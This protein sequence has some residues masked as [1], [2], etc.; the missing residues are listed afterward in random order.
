MHHHTLAPLETAHDVV[1]TERDQL[2]AECTAFETFAER[3][4]RL[5]AQASAAPPAGSAHQSLVTARAENDG[6]CRLRTAFRETIMAVSHYNAIYDE[7]L[8]VHVEGELGPDIATVM[9]SDGSLTPAVTQ[10]VS[11]AVQKGIDNRTAV[12]ELVDTELDSLAT[13]RSDLATVAMALR[14]HS[15]AD[16]VGSGAEVDSL[17]TVEQCCRTVVEDR[18]ALVQNRQ[19]SPLIDGHDLC[20]YLYG[21]VERWTYPVLSVAASLQQDIDA[22]T[23]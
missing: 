1:T 3:L 12:L 19:V 22:L 16:D 11:A 20:A 4:E 21:D 14:D 18:Q 7:P 9:G 2:R 5:D 8:L 23:C 17:A 6:M 15:T 10:A 13:A